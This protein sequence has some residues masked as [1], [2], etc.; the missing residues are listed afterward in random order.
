M[1]QGTQKSK[2]K[3]KTPF[4]QSSTSLINLLS[5][6]DKEQVADAFY[7]MDKIF[8]DWLD[9]EYADDRETRS[10]MLFSSH[11]IA[12]LGVIIKAIPKKKLQSLYA[13]MQEVKEAH[14]KACS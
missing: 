1:S 11:I 3:A 14:N 5:D 2:A 8:K 9:T 6:Y 4:C 10:Q 7:D 12:E 13:E